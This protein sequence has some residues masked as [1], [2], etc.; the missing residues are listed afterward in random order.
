MAFIHQNKIIVYGFY[1]PKQDYCM[2]LLYTKTR[3]SGANILQNHLSYAIIY[4]N[5]TNFDAF[6][7]IL[8]SPKSVFAFP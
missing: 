7:A 1:T 3:L 5:K 8:A 6:M 2:W 4:V